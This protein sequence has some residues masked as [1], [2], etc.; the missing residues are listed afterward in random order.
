MGNNAQTVVT[1]KKNN[2]VDVKMQLTFYFVF[3][4][5]ILDQ[6]N[7]KGFFLW[8]SH[9]PIESKGSNRSELLIF[10]IVEIII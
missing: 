6:T 2:L 4:V 10:L 9:Y 3:Y 8:Y 5:F 7:I 1:K